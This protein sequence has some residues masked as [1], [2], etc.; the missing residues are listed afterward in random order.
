MKTVTNGEKL[1]YLIRDEVLDQTGQRDITW[2]NI[3][4]LLDD[5]SGNK[6]FGNYI[7]GATSIFIMRRLLKFWKDERGNTN[8]SLYVRKIAAFIKQEV[9]PGLSD[10]LVSKIS[11]AVIQADGASGS[12][13]GKQVKKNVL[14][15]FGIITCYLCGRA[16]DRKAKKDD[17]AH[18]TFEHL[19][20]ASIGGVLWTPQSRQ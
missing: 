3:G 19:W 5:V 12:P 6:E 20:P 15:E 14:Q 4:T 10:A 9:F 17:D 2:S 7:K 13:I 8:E 1:F 18:L 11:R 16:L